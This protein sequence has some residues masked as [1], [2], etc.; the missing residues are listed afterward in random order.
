MQNKETNND[1]VSKHFLLQDLGSLLE[2]L[3][4]SKN[5]SERNKIQVNLINSGLRDLKEEIKNMGE[6]EKQIENPDEIVSLVEMIF[7]FN[8]Q[9][10]GQGLKIL[11]PNQMFSRLPISLAQLKT[12]QG[13]KTDAIKT[14]YTN[15]VK[16][17][18]LRKQYCSEDNAEKLL[19]YLK[20][21]G[22]TS[23]YN[24][25]SKDLEEYAEL[26]NNNILKEITSKQNK[27][28][29]CLIC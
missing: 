2:K 12:R 28:L 4:R 29:S 19:K 23:D 16:E 6:E 22:D 11:T 5:D 7:E 15:L 9:Q 8:R 10:Q 3:W 14:L 20:S 21:L 26:L 24:E 17:Q 18:E 27:L 13:L 1:L 25:F